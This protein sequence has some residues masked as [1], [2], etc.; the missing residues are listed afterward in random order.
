MDYEELLDKAYENV[1]QTAHC[2]RFEIIKVEGHQQGNKTI[3]SNFAQIVSCLR[4][5]SEH[6]VKFLYK[7]LAAPGIIEGDR[8]ILTRKISSKDINNKIEKYAKTYVLC[9]NCKKP[10]TEI[11]EDDGKSFLRCL[12]CGHKKAISSK[13]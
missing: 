7:E 5:D 4:R 12:A 11:V 3:I 10:D 6:V 2:E 8:L 9:P 1:K 13:V